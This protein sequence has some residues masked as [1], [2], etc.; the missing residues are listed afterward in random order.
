MQHITEVTPK[1]VQLIEL[2]P[3]HSGGVL[4]LCWSVLDID[5]E[6]PVL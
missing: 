5:E 6:A 3:K 1:R 2:L 4:N